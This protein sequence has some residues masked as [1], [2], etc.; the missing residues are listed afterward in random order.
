MTRIKFIKLTGLAID[1]G[2]FTFSA[3]KEQY[4]YKYSFFIS[5]KHGFL[6]QIGFICFLLT[7]EKDLSSDQIIEHLKTTEKD[8]WVNFVRDPIDN[9]KHSSFQLSIGRLRITKDSAST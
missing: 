3:E 9:G 6:N 7:N 8:K 5:I 2:T 1:T 4:Q